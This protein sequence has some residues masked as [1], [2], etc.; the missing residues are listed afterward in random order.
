M[1]KM[2]HICGVE[3]KKLN[4][5]N[6]NHQNENSL[7][8]DDGDCIS[9]CKFCG[10]KLEIE[11]IKGDGLSPSST[12]LINPA[13]SLTS[14]D[15]CV[16]SCS[17]FSV[18]VNSYGRGNQEES[19]PLSGQEE[20]N[21]RLDGHLH[22]LSSAAPANR[23]YESNTVMEN[24]L[25]ES[26]NSNNRNTVR[27]VEIVQT[28]DCQEA[29]ENGVE[30]TSRSFNEDTEMSNSL[31]KELDA[32][33]WEPPKAE[34]SE[35]D[36][37]GSVANV[38]DDEDDECECGDG[39]K[40][41]KPSSLS[42][43]REEGSGSYRFKEGKQKVMEEVINGKFKALVNRLLK[44]VGI[45]SSGED[46]ESWVDIVTSLSWEA[47]SFLKPDAIAGQAMDPDG[48]VKVKCIATG[49]RSQ[50]QVIKGL[51]FK[52]HAAH[53]HMP[54]KCKNPRLLLIQGMLGQSS[55][56]L[57]SFD[58]MEQ[59]K[60]YLKSV[61]DTIDKCRPNV[62]LVEKNVSRDVQESILAKGMTLVLDMKLHRLERIARCTGSP[63]ISSDTLMN[64]KLRHCD[65]FYFEKFVEE[66]AGIG[67]AGKRPSKTLM[68]LVGCPTRLGCTILLKGTH[69]EELKRIKCVVQCAVVMAYHL[70]LETSFLVDQK[71][72]FSTIPLSGVANA[73]PTDLLTPFVGS[74]NSSV[75]CLEEPTAKTA[76]SCTTI[77]IPISNGFH[78]GGSHNLNLGLEGNSTLS[79]V[80]YNPAILSGRSSLSSSLEKVI[81]DRFPLVS[82]TYPSLFPYFGFNEKETDSQIT[83]AVPVLTSTEVFDHCDMETK[84]SSDEE[85][86]LDNEQSQSLAPCYE[87]PLETRKA[88][89]NNENQM[90]TNDDIRTVLDSQSILVLMSIRNAS[91]GTICEQS[92]FSHIKFYRN[93]D[94]PLGK[95]L[96]DNILNQRRPCATCGELP[97]AHF[98]YYA[99]HNRQLSIQVKRLPG[100]NRLPGEAEG[101]LWMWSRCGKCRLG[102]GIT[103]ST[104]RVLISTAA[105]GLSFGKF[106]E[107]SLSHH[108]SSSRLSICGHSL[109]RDFLHF[110]GL[111][112]M[113]AMFCYSP[114]AIYTMSVPPQR[115]EF[116]NPIRQEWL[117]KETE[118]VYMKGMLVFMEVENS[119]KKLGSQF[120]GSTLNLHGS[121]KEFSDIEEMLRQERS[122]FE[123]NIRNAAAKNGNPNQAV[124]KFLQL[125]R[126]LWEL[127][128]VSCIWDRRLHSLL[129]PDPTIMDTDTTDKAMQRELRNG[130]AGRGID[131]AAINLDNGDEVLDGRAGVK[132]QLETCVEASEF[133]I[134]IPIEGPFQVSRDRDDP[135]K[136]SVEAE[137]I[138][139]PNV[140]SLNP[141]RS[142]DQDFSVESN[143]SA[144]L[145]SGDKNCQE[146][147]VPLSGHL[148]VD[149]TIPNT[150]DIGNTGSVNLNASEK[151]MSPDSLISNL[152]NSKGWVWTPFPELRREYMKDLQEGYLPKFES[153][154]S[155]T[156]EFLPTVYKLITEEGSRLHIPLS[157]EEYIVSD[158]EGELSSVIACALA[159]LKDRPV[160]TEDLDEDTR[161]EKGMAAKTNESL[162]SLTRIASMTL[163]HWSSSGSLDADGMHSTSFS[164]EESRFSSFDGLNLLDSLVSFKSP[165]REVSLGVLKSPGKGRYSV[166]C[167]YASQFRDLRN[168][169]CPSEH[170]YIASLSRCRNWDAKGGKSKAFFAKTLDDRFII[171][172]IKKTEFESFMKFAPD[173]FGY[174]NQSFELGNQ[175][176]LA[177]I[178]GI[179][180]VFFLKKFFFL[181]FDGLSFLV[182]SIQT[183]LQVT[184]RQTKSGKEMKHDLMVMENLSFGRNI[185][186]QY[187][188]K[189]ALHARYSSAAD[190]SGDVLL[191]QNFVNDMNASPLYVSNKAKCLL[192][193]AVW[194]DTTFLDSINVMD[195]SL[196]VGVDNQ[197]RELVC[198]I[199]D[200]LRQ[201]TWDKQLETWVKSSLVVP[202]N[203]RPT[204]ISPKEYKQRFRGFM[205]THILSVPDLW[206]SQRC[207]NP[208]ELCGI[209]EDGSSP[210]ESQKQEEQ[211]GF[212]A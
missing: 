53:K 208:C 22:N 154:S 205:S 156:P 170:D 24:N 36:M 88:G 131:G 30:S 70:I 139:R 91:R 197:R 78:E 199:I 37:E 72:M 203:V 143:P 149:R 33:I 47:A 13:V 23:L 28:S 140:G 105:R 62:I 14:S 57:S 92:H 116:N 201:Y 11:S 26:I 137:E 130:T 191:D 31:N 118:I 76:S 145:H 95:F 133:P 185:T 85:K 204:V 184:I 41:G 147:N 153:I 198:G 212:S 107:L 136:T 161:R 71:A 112:P 179:Y 93:F 151:Y 128:L 38:D 79:Y 74:G 206:C 110:F 8:L 157:T 160:T 148:Q 42:S 125:N 113:V 2:C 9:Y 129:S 80:P 90:Q 115:L 69:S 104:K 7:K 195:Y 172:E 159:V 189:G 166:V 167:L 40:W 65:S 84:G 43:F 135:F 121:L 86:S 146:E 6:Q 209:R 1:H 98:Y 169:C 175:T 48:Y 152:E 187:D 186:R 178:L 142:S 55:S 163:P 102:N 174:M 73:M 200:Y 192:Q 87:A 182:L 54:T 119:L 97:E 32:N 4:E 49:S 68:F 34:D 82:S 103:K 3:F 127:L 132:I 176:C 52:K 56:G 67:E 123:V 27:D 21:N 29:R 138:E 188:L 144:H 190:G 45:V 177:K 207:S 106:L 158:Y 51:V 18:D 181:P 165:D 61:I 100:E 20:P 171:K 17:E 180:Q 164:S 150:R 108:S 46:G 50:S 39:T 66:H 81:G 210:S 10:G 202:K 193:R 35:D 124:Y 155:Y 120:A 134:K 89:S 194:N 75:S 63:T 15:S 60:D 111:G 99:H 183:S 12:L 122:E 141:D 117:L 83:T 77:D 168:R 196:L 109:Q 44:S 211:N 19:A 5:C 64:Q 16:S 173:Y 25:M 96:R 126:L 59:E 94:V 58:S 101:K 114:V 162:H